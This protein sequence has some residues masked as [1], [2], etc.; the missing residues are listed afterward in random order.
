MPEHD[1]LVEQCKKSWLAEFSKICVDCKAPPG[2]PHI[3]GCRVKECNKERHNMCPDLFDENGDAIPARPANSGIRA[4]S[5]GGIVLSVDSS[6]LEAGLADAAN[7]VKEFCVFGSAEVAEP[8]YMM[9]WL[10]RRSMIEF[11]V[12]KSR[13]TN[14]PADAIIEAMDHDI[15]RDAVGLRIRSREFPQ[16]AD[17]GHIKSMEAIVER[18]IVQSGSDA[19]TDQRDVIEHLLDRDVRLRYAY[20][21]DPIVHV[22][23]YHALRGDC[24]LQDAL[25]MCVREMANQNRKLVLM[26]R[27]HVSL[28]SLPLIS[29]TDVFE[30]LKKDIAFKV[31]ED[32]KTVKVGPRSR[33]ALDDQEKDS[34]STLESKVPVDWKIQREQMAKEQAYNTNSKEWR[35]A[36]HDHIRVFECSRCGRVGP[37]DRVACPSC[38]PEGAKANPPE[39][40]LMAE[41][42]QTVARQ[43]E[44]AVLDAFI[45]TSKQ[46]TCPAA[47]MLAEGWR[48]TC[49]A[50]P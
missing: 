34:L 11:L 21:N 30:R 22:C 2:A 28:E 15:Q 38:D 29:A 13:I 40:D 36:H 24:T 12:G 44:E 37:P 14:L 35:A 50:N 19:T 43:R 17:G 4:G 46:C 8:G 32:R 9:L 10:T 41:Y 20:A 45:G 16:V 5:S 26:L 49:G 18:R 27:E 3:D 7:K 33:E 48:C 42:G 31:S 47:D 1:M 23:L 6:A 25:V 39:R